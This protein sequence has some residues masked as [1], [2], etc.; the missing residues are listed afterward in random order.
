MNL[1]DALKGTGDFLRGLRFDDEPLGSHEGRLIFF[2]HHELGGISLSGN[3]SE[4]YIG[5]L[6]S[7]ATSIARKDS[8]SRRG[9]EQLLQTAILNAAKTASGSNHLRED[10]VKEAVG[11]LRQELEREPYRYLVFLPVQGIDASNLPLA[12]GSVTFVPGNARTI[13][14]IRR[15]VRTIVAGLKN[16]LSQKKAARKLFDKDISNGFRDKIVAQLEVHAGDDNHA[17]EK[18]YRECRR[19]VDVI[20]FF[21]DIIVDRAVKTCVSLLGEGNPVF[22]VARKPDKSRLTLLLREQR[23]PGESAI[24]YKGK[25]IAAFHF[26]PTPLGPLAA[27]P[28]PR[29]ESTRAADLGFSRVSQLLANPARAPFE[30]LVLTALQWA[31]RATVDLRKE[32]AFLLY[33]IALESLILGGDSHP[34]L[35]YRLKFQAAHLLGDTLNNRKELVQRIGNLYDVRSK[36]VHSGSF[37]VTDFELREARHYTKLALLNVITAQPYRDMKSWSEFNSWLEGQLLG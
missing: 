10:S 34:E 26:H 15:P 37:Q 35:K 12:F 14:G 31:G 28:L 24:R 17:E 1:H 22:R 3:D 13:E 7:L 29:R 27:M 21:S 25:R 33:L 4:R 36:I 16:E 32:E 18:A 20:N 6:D 11:W 9:V 5:C 30:E 2:T 23:D 19:T 8:F